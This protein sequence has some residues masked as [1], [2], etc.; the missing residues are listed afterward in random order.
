MIKLPSLACTAL[1]LLVSA[2]G[3]VAQQAPDAVPDQPFKTV[4]LMAATSTDEPAL[5]TAISALNAEVKRQ[6][7][8]R[9]AYHLSRMFVGSQSPYSYMMTSDWPSRTEYLRV[10]DSAG[11]VSVYA[12]NPILAKLERTQFYGRFVE[13]E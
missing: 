4:H 1:L 3:S 11:F 10:H 13:V 9:C 12:G 2:S 7:C 5:K 6:G 8:L